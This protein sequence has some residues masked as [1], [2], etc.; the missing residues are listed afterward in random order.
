MI[1]KILSL[2]I[3]VLLTSSCSIY[4]ITSQST[5]DT[6]YPSRENGDVVYLDRIDDTYEIIGT[7]TVNAE[8]RQRLSD[9]IERMKREAAIL[10]G[11]AITNI[12]SDATGPWKRLPIQ[13]TIGNAY[14]RA[15]FTA[16]VVVGNQ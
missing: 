9:V 7:V 2:V 1:K 13:K 4:N 10:G 3:L 11:E 12:Q 5:T 16:S 14:V 8:R 15:N 6:Y